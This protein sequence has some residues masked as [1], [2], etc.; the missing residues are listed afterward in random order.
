MAVLRRRHG[1]RSQRGQSLVE[2]AIVLPFLM[3]LILGAVEFGFMFNSDLSLEYASR[4]GAR[5]GASLVN[6]GGTLGCGSGR[7]PNA[8]TV[9]EQI[10]Q[11]VNRVLTSTGSPLDVVD[12]LEIRIFKANAAGGEASGAVNVWLPTPGSGPVVDGQPLDFTQSSV[13][14]QPCS[15]TYVQPADSIGVG[16]RYRYHFKTPFLALIGTSSVTMYDKTVMAM[17]PTS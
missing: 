9:D 3:L 4:E 13:G 5:L 7:S 10:V 12:V 6:G 11:A 1:R 2:F 16:V 15:R 8:G 17:N 14:W